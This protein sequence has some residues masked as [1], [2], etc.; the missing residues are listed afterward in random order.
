M[1]FP[2]LSPSFRDLVFLLSPHQW[3]P[4]SNH[5]CPIRGHPSG[6][7][8]YPPHCRLSLSPYPFQLPLPALPEALFPAAHVQCSRFP[9]FHS[10]CGSLPLF[11]LP[12]STTAVPSPFLFC[13]DGTLS[14]FLSYGLLIHCFL[15]CPF[16]S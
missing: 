2:S 12:L 6:L 5:P 10:L 9:F 13:S 8:R 3:S 15:S 14:L 7:Q 1:L 4:F 16:P 11:P